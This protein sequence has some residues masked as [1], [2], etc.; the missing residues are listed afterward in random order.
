MTETLSNDK[1]RRSF[2]GLSAEQRQAERYQKLMEAGLQ[3]GKLC[4]ITTSFGT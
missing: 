1:K 3:Y 2:K 4:V